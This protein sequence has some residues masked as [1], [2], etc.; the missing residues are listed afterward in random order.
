MN[1][2]NEIFTV[3]RRPD[4]SARW[5]VKMMSVKPDRKTIAKREDMMAI[6]M[7]NEDIIRLF[8]IKGAEWLLR[9][10]CLTKPGT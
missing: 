10:I 8:W 9:T 6:A 4:A 2:E 1:N 7:P 3:G 5:S